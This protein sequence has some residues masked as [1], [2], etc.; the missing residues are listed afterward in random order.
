MLNK[1]Y[2]ANILHPGRYTK[3]LRQEAGTG[4]RKRVTVYGYS[5]K[6][7]GG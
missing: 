7:R 5:D 4:I 3:G 2:C 6:E 1:R